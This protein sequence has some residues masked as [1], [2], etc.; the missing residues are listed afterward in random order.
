MKSRPL[1]TKLLPICRSALTAAPY[2]TPLS[3]HTF[4]PLGTLTSV[5]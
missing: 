2:M 1:Y 3:S 4:L 5:L